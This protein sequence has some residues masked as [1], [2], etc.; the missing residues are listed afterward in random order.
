VPGWTSTVLPIYFLGGIQLFSLG[1]IGEYL[2]KTYME[3]KRRPRYVIDQAIGYTLPIP[4][5]FQPRSEGTPHQLTPRLHAE[6]A[7]YSRAQYDVVV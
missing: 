7:A 1:I 3:S 2:A 5:T 4:R 6:D